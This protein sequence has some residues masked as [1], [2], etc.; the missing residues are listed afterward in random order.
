MPC[1]VGIPRSYGQTTRFELGEWFG[2]GMDTLVV[3]VQPGFHGERY[4]KHKFK[5]EYNYEIKTNIKKLT[6]DIIQ[7]IKELI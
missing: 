3:G 1:N 4:I 2:K 7:K 5:Q 6:I